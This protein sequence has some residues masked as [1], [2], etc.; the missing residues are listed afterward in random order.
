MFLVN[1]LM[2]KAE[3]FKDWFDSPY[4]HILYQNRDQKEAAAFIDKLSDHLKL[5]EDD[6]I[7]DLACGMGR[8]STY[9][10]SKGFRV[11]GTDLS[12]NNISAALKNA[13]DR[14]DFFVH[15]MRSPFRI[16]YFT[17]V[18]NLFTSIGYFENFS[19]NMKVFKNVCLALKPGGRFVIDFFNAKQVTDKLPMSEQKTIRG[20]DFKISKRLEGKHLIKRIEFSDKGKNYFFE[21]NVTLLTRADFER[22]AERVGFEPEEIFG[23]YNLNPF[24]PATS[25]RLILIFKK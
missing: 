21:E 19:D 5:K 9:L 2:Q 7:W 24:D 17:H 16:N 6:V 13:N 8:H 10:N 4:Y 22:F 15:D 18:F 1:L 12:G 3:W 14:L 11:I 23:D 25:E 20:I